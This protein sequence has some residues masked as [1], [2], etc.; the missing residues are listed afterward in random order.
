[1]SPRAHQ[2]ANAIVCIRRF[3]PVPCRSLGRDSAPPGTESPAGRPVRLRADQPPRGGNRQRRAGRTGTAGAGGGHACRGA[4][5]ALRGTGG[6]A[7]RYGAGLRGGRGPEGAAASATA[8]DGGRPRTAAG[9]LPRHAGPDD[10]GS[11]GPGE[12]DRRGGPAPGARVLRARPAPARGP[13]GVRRQQE[14]HQPTLDR[15]D[16]REPGRADEPSPTRPQ[17]L[18]A[19]R[20]LTIAVAAAGPP[21]V[22]LLS[23]ACTAGGPCSY[24]P[25]GPITLDA[26]TG[27][28]SETVGSGRS[29]YAFSARLTGY[30]ALAA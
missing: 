29:R 16:G 8:T 12:G 28:G 21:A 25:A 13:A 5:R 30:P 19:T 14:Q 26:S 18:S 24:T 15:G 20:S 27:S 11:G 2:G 1:M 3:P 22:T 23:E 6:Q 17:A 7:Q 10:P 4:L 9:L